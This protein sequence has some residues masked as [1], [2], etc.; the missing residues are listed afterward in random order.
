[1]IVIWAPYDSATACRLNKAI[2]KEGVECHR[3]KSIHDDCPKGFIVNWG[4]LSGK[5]A[6][7]NGKAPIGNKL[8][9]LLKLDGHVRIPPVLTCMPGQAGWLARKIHHVDG[10]DLEIDGTHGDFWT[11]LIPTTREFRVHAF[12]GR[13]I[14]LGERVPVKK[15]HHPYLRTIT[16]GWDIEYPGMAPGQDPIGL[17][18]R[19]KLRAVAFEAVKAVGYDFGGVDIGLG[20]DGKLYVFEVNSAPGLDPGIEVNRYV[21]AIIAASKG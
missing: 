2:N 11:K 8:K 18:L 20:E 16:R 1:M 10:D 19:Q 6:D 12:R 13:S 7:L 15:D 5:K 21:E 9:E 4:S 17:T 3:H 14:L